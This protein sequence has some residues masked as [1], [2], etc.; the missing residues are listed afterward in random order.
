MDFAGPYAVG[1]F[2]RDAVCGEAVRVEGDGTPL[3]SYLYAADLAVWL[4]TILF[5][6]E[7]AAPYNV[8]SPDAISIAELAHLVAHTVASAKPVVVTQRARAN[9]PPARYVPDVSRAG[10]LGLHTT[11][12]LE[13]AIRRTGD[14]LRWSFNR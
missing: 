10:T 9:L 11:V 12:S 4:W 2:I 3:R 5:R 8:G 14:W 7:S 6:G 1:N 13:Q